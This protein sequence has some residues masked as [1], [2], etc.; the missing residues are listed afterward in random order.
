MNL[1]ALDIMIPNMQPNRNKK[2]NFRTVQCF[3]FTSLWLA[4]CVF[5]GSLLDS[6]GMESF[7]AFV[8]MACREVKVF[9]SFASRNRNTFLGS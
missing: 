3:P 2:H 4:I 8:D 9:K 1:S 7:F 5:G 6:K